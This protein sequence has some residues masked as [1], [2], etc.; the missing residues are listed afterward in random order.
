MHMDYVSFL[1]DKLRFVLV[2]G[3]DCKEKT[4]K[5]S[6][7][8]S[9]F[10]LFNWFAISVYLIMR[11]MSNILD[12]N[13]NVYLVIPSL[14]SLKLRKKAR[15]SKT[16]PVLPCGNAFRSSGAGIFLVLPCGDASCSLAGSAGMVLPLCLSVSF[17]FSSPSLLCPLASDLSFWPSFWPPFRP[18]PC[19]YRLSSEGS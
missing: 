18:P 8:F 6:D 13:S 11:G 7:S 9:S 1:P 3:Q 12:L 19:R 15:F 14:Q 5:I 17:L 2:S 4:D 16:G 10:F